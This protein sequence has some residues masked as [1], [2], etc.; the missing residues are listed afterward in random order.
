L[1]E[2]RYGPELDV[3]SVGCILAEMYHKNPLFPGKDYQDQ[4]S[5]IFS[6]IGS[7]TPEDV[8]QCV[9]EEV[10]ARNFLRSLGDV[11]AKNWKDVLPNASEEAIDLI[12]RL[13]CF[14]P[15]KRLTIDEALRHPFLASYFNED[16]VSNDCVA[17]TSLDVSYEK[18]IKDKEDT[19]EEMFEE[20][21]KFRPDAIFPIDDKK[22]T[23][24]AK[25]RSQNGNRFPLFSSNRQAATDN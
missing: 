25:P 15:A 13:L 7:P 2:R 12:S 23:R 17:K 11:P 24:A 5:Q 3:W 4:L 16:F 20:M 21:L 19:R 8:S 1:N 18:R 9:S 22:P 10:G 14:N 6:V